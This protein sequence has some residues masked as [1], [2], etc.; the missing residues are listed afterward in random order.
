MT[1]ELAWP[2]HP[3]FPSYGY[4]VRRRDL[5]ELVAERAVE[6]GAELWTGAEAVEPVVDDGL[7][8]GAVVRRGADVAEPVRAKYVVV[9]DGSTSRFGRALGTARDRSYP[10]GM[11]L[12]GYFTA[13]TTTSRGSRA[14]S[15]CAT[16][17]A[18]TCPGTAGSSRS[19]TAP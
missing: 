7:V 9:A 4:V 14:T 19:A 1:L 10:L 13:R 8:A 18:T 11:A 17:T 3:D 5:D 6:A 12:R 16:A 2:E 15:T